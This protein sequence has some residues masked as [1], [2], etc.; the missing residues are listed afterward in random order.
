MRACFSYLVPVQSM[1][2]L[3]LIEMSVPEMVACENNFSIRSFNSLRKMVDLVMH[4]GAQA[5]QERKCPQL[6]TQ[7]LRGAACPWR[8][9]GKF[10]GMLHFVHNRSFFEISTCAQ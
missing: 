5:R 9:S 7:L 8:K 1:T 3:V 6:V 2:R 4:V 10:S